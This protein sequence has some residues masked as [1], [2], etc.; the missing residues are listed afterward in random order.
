MSRENASAYIITKIL[1]KKEIISLHCDREQ[2]KREGKKKK[3][4][5]KQLMSSAKKKL[6]TLCMY[7]CSTDSIF[8]FFGGGGTIQIVKGHLCFILETQTCIVVH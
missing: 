7:E 3:L 8:F 6:R 5:S 1:H 4:S 2:V